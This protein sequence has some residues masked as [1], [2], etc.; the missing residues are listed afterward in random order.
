MIDEMHA[1]EQVVLVSLY[2]FLL[3]RKG[4]SSWWSRSPQSSST[5]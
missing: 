2:L 3:V 4:R 1:L 5:S